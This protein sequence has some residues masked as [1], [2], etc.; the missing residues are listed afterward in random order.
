MIWY[1][2]WLAAASALGMLIT[3]VARSFN[4]DVEYVIPAT[5][6]E[7]IENERHRGRAQASQRPADAGA[8]PQPVQV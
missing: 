1:I 3:V 7:R 6:V 4:D 8:I 2:W 5:E